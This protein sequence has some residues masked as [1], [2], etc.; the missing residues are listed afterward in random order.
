[1][2]CHEVCVIWLTWLWFQCYSER[3]KHHLSL[4]TVKTD[5][6]PGKT[7]G[8]GKTNLLTGLGKF[9]DWRTDLC[10][11]LQQ[12]WLIA[13]CYFHSSSWFSG[14]F[15][16]APNPKFHFIQ[17]KITLLTVQLRAIHVFFYAKAIR[18]I[19]MKLL[20]NIDNVYDFVWHLIKT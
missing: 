12:E 4:K 3:N 11:T 8:P 16:W 9:C 2:P 18:V 19:K 7:K 20:C 15:V 5:E 14:E 13:S 6:R 1:M 17:F 10:A